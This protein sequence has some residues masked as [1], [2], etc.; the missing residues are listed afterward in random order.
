MKHAKG[1]ATMILVSGEGPL[2]AA[3]EQHL[4]K[5][6]AQVERMGPAAVAGEPLGLGAFSACP[7]VSDYSR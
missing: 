4:R 3:I 1:T 7:R 2:A 5:A 6:G